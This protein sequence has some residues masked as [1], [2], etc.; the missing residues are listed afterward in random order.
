MI[1]QAFIISRKPQCGNMGVAGETRKLLL[2][3]PILYMSLLEIGETDLLFNFY[4]VFDVL[5]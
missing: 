2:H 4:F 5:I 1:G 3:T